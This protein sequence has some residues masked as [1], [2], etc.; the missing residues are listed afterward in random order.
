MLRE[1]VLGTCYWSRERTLEQSIENML[2]FGW[3]IYLAFSKA[4]KTLKCDVLE[5]TSHVCRHRACCASVDVSGQQWP[6]L[7][8]DTVSHFMGSSS[9]CSMYN[10]IFIKIALTLWRPL[11]PSGYSY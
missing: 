10:D 6:S 9:A 5:W 7:S 3:V 11:L 4:E 8:I 2:S 1:A